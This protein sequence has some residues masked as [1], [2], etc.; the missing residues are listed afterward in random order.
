MGYVAL[1]RKYRPKTFKDVV[2]QDTVIRILKNS[3]T[4]NKIGHAYIF[5]GTRGT[6]KTSIA[7]IFSRAINCLDPIEGD[8]CQKC[9]V[10]KYIESYNMDIVEIDAASNN[11]VEEIREIRN[12]ANLLPTNLKYK[13]YIIDEVH[14]L[15]GSA[16]NA[17]LKTLEEPFEHI[18]F[19]LATTELN[20]IPATVLS[21]CQKLDFKKITPKVLED[22]LKFI[23]DK[24]Q[25]NISD[26]VI[27][28]VATI[29]DGS[30]RDAINYI[31]QLIAFDKK[32]ITV[33]DVYDLIG[34]LPQE[35]IINIVK[36]MFHS[37][38]SEGLNLINQM[39]NE[40]KN[41]YNISERTQNIVRDI[42]IF[43]S[44]HGYFDEDYEKKL[45]MFIN[46][47]T[48]K[49]IE[50]S[51]ILFNLTN[52]LKKTAN[53]KTLFET[54][55]IKICLLFNVKT[56]NEFIEE[57]VES[58]NNIQSEQVPENINSKEIIDISSKQV[59]INNTLACA[60]KDN[61]KELQDKYSEINDYISNKDYNSICTLMFKAVPEVVSDKNILFT[62]K[63][64]FEVVL[65]DKNIDS[66]QKLLKDIYKK[67]YDI[68]A[69]DSRQW[70]SIKDKYIE[71]TKNGVK[72]T[73]VKE[74]TINKKHK[75]VTALEKE[76]ENIFGD[77]LITIE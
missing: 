56:M 1:Y 6:G 32:D 18:V 40:G 34:D 64:S 61:K 38:I 65:F 7:K 74:E 46:I 39:F 28:L 22:Q 71:D 13:V 43:N 24:E 36:Y 17:L 67:K 29:S 19:I 14:M 54:Y 16:F 50:V 68:V 73:Y 37:D 25:I 49:C 59:R 20:K 11:G 33:E 27:K 53:Q 58:K 4:S 75:N 72:Y 12:N 66:I 60:S 48:D 23:L 45:E 63:N 10:C 26:N 77:D 47:D 51:N 31:D 41:F 42:I 52:T 30:L 76:V 2:G 70:K 8:V 15:S 3:I 55:F 9:D 35:Q 69:V 57:K 62:F 5:S 44:T 21:R